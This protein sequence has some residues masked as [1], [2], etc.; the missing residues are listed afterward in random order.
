[1]TD[2]S[3]VIA[4][5]CPEKHNQLF[6][7]SQSRQQGRPV[8][9]K[10]T[11]VDPYSCPRRTWKAVK[12]NSKTVV[13]GENCSVYTQLTEGLYYTK[14]GQQYEWK[15][16]SSSGV[17][18]SRTLFSILDECYRILKV[19]GKVIF[20]DDALP[21]DKKIQQ[22]A[23][24]PNIIKRYNF[25]VIPVSASKIHLAQIDGGRLTTRNYLYVFTKKHREG[26]RK[27]ERLKRKQ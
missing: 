11:Y 17:G 15:D 5:H 23:N 10:A 2:S 8:G 7:I 6:H 1:M 4:C 12:A 22:I 18:S 20:G 19:R 21:D 14:K 26:T 24:H 25:E 9:P 27:S 13:W 16:D 3:L